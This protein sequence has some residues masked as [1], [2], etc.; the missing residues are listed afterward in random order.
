MMNYSCYIK[1]SFYAVLSMLSS[2]GESSVLWLCGRWRVRRRS[3]KPWS[4]GGRLNCRRGRGP[5]RRVSHTCRRSRRGSRLW[6]RDS[7]T[8]PRYSS[9]SEQE[10]NTSPSNSLHSKVHPTYPPLHYCLFWHKNKTSKKLRVSK[11]WVQMRCY[12][13]L[14]SLV[15][16]IFKSIKCSGY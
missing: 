7:Q 14:M 2:V 3:A 16:Q 1:I 10:S 8:L 6:S 9:V 12:L 11:I 13:S 15:L 5:W 4:T